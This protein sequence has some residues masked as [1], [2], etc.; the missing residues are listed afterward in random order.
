MDTKTC[1]CCSHSLPLHLF[2][3][4]KSK[5]DLL[6][7]YCRSCLKEKQSKYRSAKPVD[8]AKVNEYRKKW[9]E[10][11]PEKIKSAKRAYYERNKEQKQEYD[12]KYREK[13]RSRR[14]E[15]KES[16]LKDNPDYYK[17]VYRK[18]KEGNAVSL[19]AGRIANRLKRE[20]AA[21]ALQDKQYWFDKLNKLFLYCGI[22]DRRMNVVGTKD[23][24]NESVSIDRINNLI[25]YT[26]DN[27]WLIC[28]GCNASKRT[29]NPNQLFMMANKVL[30][31]MASRGQICIISC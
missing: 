23:N 29:S 16:M 28:H 10:N 7:I 13:Y 22:C 21:K 4:D 3:K 8:K 20:G 31:E 6:N 9:A 11:N 18:R 19:Q 27:T 26:E 2:S 30:E 24:Q 14:K 5:P 12:K 15:L 1:S 25:G 17:E